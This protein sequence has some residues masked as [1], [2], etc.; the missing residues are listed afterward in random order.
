MMTRIVIGT[1]SYCI[2]FPEV[3]IN[4]RRAICTP[5]QYFTALR[6]G[7][8][9]L[10]QQLNNSQIIAWNDATKSYLGY[11]ILKFLKIS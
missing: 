5:Q 9:S 3:Q 10:K 6:P 4:H 11:P 7:R 8:N 2:T 1:I